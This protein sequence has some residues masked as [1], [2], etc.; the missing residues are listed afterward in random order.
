MPGS[1]PPAR[2]RFA[3]RGPRLPAR[4]SKGHP[5]LSC[6]RCRGRCPGQMSISLDTVSAIPPAAYRRIAQRDSFTRYRSPKS[7]RRVWPAVR[8]DSRHAR[9]RTVADPR[10]IASVA[11]L[12]LQKLFRQPK[13]DV[14]VFQ[15]RQW[16]E[17]FFRHQRVVTPESL[18][19]PHGR[20]GVVAVMFAR[21][22]EIW[23]AQP[24]I[25]R[26]Q[27]RRPGYASQATC[28][29]AGLRAKTNSRLSAMCIV[30]STRMS[31][32]SARICSATLLRPT[33]RDVAPPSA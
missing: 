21:R 5:G 11:S 22:I 14:A 3:H 28:T 8:E 2:P 33:A 13:R 12:T 32:P 24:V 1:N 9:L 4:P 18:G 31:I 26:R 17:W 23:I 20:L 25:H 27:S 7:A 19:Q 29:G 6:G 10:D 30:R 16:R 15:G